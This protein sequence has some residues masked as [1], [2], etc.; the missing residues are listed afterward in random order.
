[1]GNSFLM[2]RLGILRWLLAEHDFV[3]WALAHHFEE[4]CKTMVG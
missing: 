1:M 3:G 4:A 2:G